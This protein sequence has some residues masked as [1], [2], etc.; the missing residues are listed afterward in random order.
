MPKEIRYKVVRTHGT[1][2]LGNAMEPHHLSADYCNISH[3]LMMLPC[4]TT[5]PALFVSLAFATQI[6]DQYKAEV[7][8]VEIEEE[9]NVLV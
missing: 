5:K 6:A 9:K 3:R 2:V 4:S 1:D 8:A 7:V